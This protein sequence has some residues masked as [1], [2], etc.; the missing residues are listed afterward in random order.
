M[1]PHK[2]TSSPR[3]VRELNWPASF[4]I[5]RKIPRHARPTLRK[6]NV[7]PP[8]PLPTDHAECDPLPTVSKAAAC[9]A[10]IIRS[11]L[12]SSRAVSLL[13]FQTCLPFT[14]IKKFRRYGTG[15]IPAANRT[16]HPAKKPHKQRGNVRTSREGNPDASSRTGRKSLAAV[17]HGDYSLSP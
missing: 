17:A 12:G 2:F 10:V 6:D 14:L 16:H 7:H 3:G 5:S 8:R 1:L 4:L 9:G 15:L 11:T 13:S